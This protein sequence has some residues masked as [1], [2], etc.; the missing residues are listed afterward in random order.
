MAPT[1][2]PG[3]VPRPSDRSTRQAFADSGPLRSWPKRPNDGR[4]GEVARPDVA[5]GGSWE[6]G[7]QIFTMGSCFA[8]NIED[9]L[10]TLGFS[11]PTSGFPIK[12]EYWRGRRPAGLLNVYTTPTMIRSLELAL[13]WHR[14]EEHEQ[15]ALLREGL[16]ELPEGVVD[17]LLCEPTP[18]PLASAL[19][20]RRI[21]LEVNRC[22]FTARVVVLT[23]GLVECWV[24]RTTGLTIARAPGRVRQRHMPD[25]YVLRR[26]TV[27]DVMADLEAVFALL[28]DNGQPGL[29]VVI[30]VSPV[31]LR[32]TF[33]PEDV[34]VA[35]TH[36][37]SVLRVAAGEVSARHD[38][39]SYV[40]T[41]ESVVLSQSP[42]VWEDDLR[43]VSEATVAALIGRVV[44]AHLPAEVP[45]ELQLRLAVLP[46]LLLVRRTRP[47]EWPL[48]EELQQALDALAAQL[49]ASPPPGAEL[50]WSRARALLELRPGHVP[51]ALVAED[52]GPA[53]LFWL[54]AVVN[55]LEAAGHSKEAM[56]PLSRLAV[57][58]PF[59][60]D[61]G[62]L[63]FERA[64]QHG[65]LL[66]RLHSLAIRHASHRRILLTRPEDASP[67]KQRRF[68]RSA[69]RGAAALLGATAD[70]I[71]LQPEAEAAVRAQLPK[72]SP[73][74]VAAVEQGI[75]HARRTSARMDLDTELLQIQDARLKL[76]LECWRQGLRQEPAEVRRL[77]AELTGLPG[78]AQRWR[79]RVQ[80]L[81]GEPGGR[82]IAEAVAQGLADGQRAGWAISR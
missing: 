21:A 57:S 35:N 79:A 69:G 76:E 23:L 55:L 67:L 33:M 63:F 58:R 6:L 28:R 29:Q 1:D 8:R 37:K 19:D 20:R 26:L 10:D 2:R 45:P 11:V 40:P 52:D 25:R 42:D 62:L 51:P 34:L 49:P 36:S 61:I 12:P 32:R 39:V 3:F 59:D 74:L 44:H 75:A 4:L 78:A 53:Q 30:S 54:S 64:K 70:L 81:S 66:D 80:Q 72:L 46:V 16:V 68:S 82:A 7:S 41:Y 15:D 48:F 22:A 5:T 56:G 13:R 14:A 47:V 50:W 73:P 31:P 24:D 65:T 38:F 43:H 9:V 27:N 60:P 77:A 71:R 18:L 17:D